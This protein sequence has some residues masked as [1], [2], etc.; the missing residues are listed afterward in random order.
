[1][2]M[3]RSILKVAEACDF[4]TPHWN[5]T[6]VEGIADRIASLKQFGKPIVCNEDDKIGEQAAAA[7]RATVAAGAGYGLMLKDHNQTFPFHFDGPEDDRVYYSAL[8]SHTGQQVTDT[9]STTTIAQAVYFPPPESQGGWRQV[10]TA[11]EIETIAGM[12]PAKIDRLRDWLMTSDKRDFSAVVIRRGTIALQVERGNSAVTDARRV[13]SVSKAIC[14]TVLAIASEQSQTGILPRKMSFDDRAF[15][16]IPWAKPLSDPRKSEIT[17]RQLL[18]HTSG[19][20]PEALGAPNDGSW[21]YVL[22]HSGD[23]RTE[24]LAFDPGTAC[25]YSTHGLVHASLVCE[26]VTG[27]PYDQFAIEALFKPLGIEKWWFQ[28]YD[29]GEVG[30]K[31]SHGLGLPS[32]ELARIGY[33]MLKSGKW[34]DRQVIPPWFVQQSGE[35]S[36]TV[37]TPEMRWKL[38]PQVFSLGW[39]LPARHYASSN[40][41]IQAYLSMHGTNLAAADN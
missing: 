37:T 23:A 2:A 21:S 39:E 14:A 11:A 38:N 22:G 15:D 18:N 3:A 31:A 34:N 32:R 26:T 7:L 27:K 28:Y 41:H 12:D 24:K 10:E 6:K 8:K 13:A 30:H 5:G 20:C 35:P 33:C 40:K 36:S 16:F 29:G 25:G 1:M 4:L 17:I 9:L 19:I